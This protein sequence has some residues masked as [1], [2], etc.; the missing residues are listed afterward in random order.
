MAKEPITVMLKES[1][2]SWFSS[3]SSRMKDHKV[4]IIGDSHPRNCA[5]NVKTETDTRGNLKV[6]GLV[7]PGAG[8]D[9]LVNS[10]NSDIVSL[11][12]SYV[13]IFCGGANDVG[14]NNSTK[15]LHHIMDFVKTNNHTNII[16][17]T[18]PPRYDLM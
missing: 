9:T 3:K 1:P 14:E 13:L 10:A 6:Q 16:L 15:A 12:K 5:A 18:V 8:T 2:V 17:V 7:K 4:L 11:A